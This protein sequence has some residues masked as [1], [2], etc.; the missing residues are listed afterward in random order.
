[1]YEFSCFIVSVKC[2]GVMVTLQLL[3]LLYVV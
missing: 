1:M 2:Y 3:T